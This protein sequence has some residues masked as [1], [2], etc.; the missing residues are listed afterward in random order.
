M[1]TLLIDYIQNNLILCSQY[2]TILNKAT[3]NENQYYFFR[4][5]LII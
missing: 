4:K 2:L 5:F 3:Q 1:A